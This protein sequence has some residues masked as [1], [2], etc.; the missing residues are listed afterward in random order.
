MANVE[1]EKPKSKLKGTGRGSDIAGILAAMTPEERAA[2]YAAVTKKGE[3]TRAAKR[4]EAA[5]LREKA[6]E[7][8]PVLL[9]EE[10]ILSEHENIRPSPRVLART[11]ELMD[12]GMSIEAMRKELFSRASEKAWT[13]FKKYLFQDHIAQA[14]DLGLEILNVKKRAI[15]TLKSRIREA[16][17]MIKEAKEKNR[18]FLT[19]MEM[20]QSAEDKLLEI[21]LDVSKTLYS[22]GAVGKKQGAS[23]GV[24]VNFNIPR[25]AAPA[26]VVVD[27]TPGEP[28][29]ADGD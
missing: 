17:K 5:A 9:A 12:K 15:K 10:M 23:G 13:Q 6:R 21:E 4:A 1:S 11:R 19:L 14:E 22:V 3:Q 25:P 27:V 24:T 26:S 7:L 29:G 28:G 2:H 18:P 16:K 8:V 20:R